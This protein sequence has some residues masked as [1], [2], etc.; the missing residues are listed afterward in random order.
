MRG[1]CAISR[2]GQSSACRVE[3][4]VERILQLLDDGG[5]QA[6]FFVLGWVA[7]RYSAMIVRIADA[8]HE[9]ASHGFD[10]AVVSLTEITDFRK[11]IQRDDVQFIAL[12]KPPGHALPLYPRL[13]RLLRDLQPA[14]VHTRNLA[15]LEVTVPA[16]LAGVRARVHG[17]HARLGARTRVRVGRQP[18]ARER[19]R[20][21]H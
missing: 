21:R 2:S 9:V 1:H 5:V 4:N 10:H 16:W 13:L 8:G 18:C 11:R 7:E 15:A 19:P 6:T 3:R 17:E 14:I 12:H 20:S